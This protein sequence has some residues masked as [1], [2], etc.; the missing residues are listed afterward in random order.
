MRLRPGA[1]C[2]RICKSRLTC[3]NSNPRE[4]PTDVVFRHSL[5]PTPAPSAPPHLSVS[6]RRHSSHVSIR[7]RNLYPE[8]EYF[9]QR[10][11]GEPTSLDV[12]DAPTSF[13]FDF[14]SLRPP[15]VNNTTP[16]A[17]NLAPDTT[18]RYTNH[19]LSHLPH[20]HVPTRNKLDAQAFPSS[21]SLTVLELSTKR[22]SFYSTS[23]PILGPSSVSD[24]STLAKPPRCKVS[25]ALP[26]PTL[27]VRNGS[28]WT[29]GAGIAELRPRGNFDWLQVTALPKI[30]LVCIECL[31]G[32]SDQPSG[33]HDGE[34]DGPDSFD[35]ASSISAAVDKLHLEINPEP[36]MPESSRR[37]QSP[38][39]ARSER[40][41][42]EVDEIRCAECP[43]FCVRD[44]IV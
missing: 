7:R 4:G 21:P 3:A 26:P 34:V 41:A 19:S 24:L 33:R 28:C 20:R 42:P 36:E 22:S 18:T 17:Q 25:K 39:H 35:S 5:V 29:C 32:P 8:Y 40:T 30:E 6:P 16:V 23:L 13:I 14:S 1:M 15:I 10:P 2:T 11:R 9:A 12:P 43:P 37:Q 27:L 31:D 44:G 38:V